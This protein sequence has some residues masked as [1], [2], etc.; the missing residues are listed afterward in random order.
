[1]DE[2][3]ILKKMVSFFIEPLGFVLLLFFIG[4][5]TL[6]RGHFTKAKLFLSFSF[7]FLFL[8]S[9]P[10]FS[11]I[12]VQTIEDVYPKFDVKDANISYIHVLGNGNNDDVKQPLSSML[13]D[14]SMK[15]VIEG[16]LI[17]KQ[18]PKAKLIFTGYEGESTLANAQVNAKM[19]VALGIS[20]KD[21]IINSKPKDT[22]E[23]VLFDKSI[24][25]HNKFVVVTSATH[26]LRAVKLFRDQ[27]LDPI[28]APTDYKG[29]RL[30]TFWIKPDIDTFHNS[31]MA[32]HEYVGL[33]WAI[34]VH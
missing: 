13:S 1:L 25:G 29:R 10:P 14:S 3:F 20:Q 21:M 7:V 12:L 5:Y 32:I 4:L 30:D 19:A 8:F 28:P 34:L 24:V 2:L 9:Y 31:Q 16:V 33:L 17:Q 18:Y 22:K 11:N 27:G 15:R 26:M 6:F 23:E